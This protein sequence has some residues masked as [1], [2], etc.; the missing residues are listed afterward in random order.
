MT[1]RVRKIFPVIHFTHPR[2]WQHPE[3]VE[4][5]AGYFR[6]E[7]AAREYLERR[8]WPE[9][10]ECPHCGLVNEAYRIAARGRAGLW[11]CAGCRRQ[12]SVTVGTQL[13][14]S[15]VPLHKWLLAVKLAREGA[16]AR[17]LWLEL[18][19]GSYRT[20]WRLAKRLEEAVGAKSFEAAVEEL[21]RCTEGERRLAAL[22]RY[23]RAL[24]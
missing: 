12:F 3:M 16:S 5:L 23:G 7:M 24:G 15:H 21:G 14:D 20:A 1:E 18:E 8:F 13:A 11:K 9:G 10:P 2:I 4:R 6:D 22:D 19:L 17:S